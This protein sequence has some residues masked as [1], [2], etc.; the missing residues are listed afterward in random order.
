[1]SRIE[2]EEGF[3]DDFEDFEDLDLNDE[4]SLLDNGE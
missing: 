2:D 3:G 4:E 1:M